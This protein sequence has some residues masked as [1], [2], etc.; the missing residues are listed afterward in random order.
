V[1]AGREDSDDSR[2]WVRALAQASDWVISGQ[3]GYKHLS[4]ATAEEVNHFI[5]WME[6]QGKKMIGR[7]ERM[8][9]NAHGVL[10]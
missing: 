10:G 5:H 9:R 3:K 2:R 6:S 1:T 7:A 4:H 8:R